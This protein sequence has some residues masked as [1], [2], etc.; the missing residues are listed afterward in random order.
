M[1]I[2]LGIFIFFLVNNLHSQE[3]SLDSLV[4]SFQKQDILFYSLLENNIQSD[5]IQKIVL[6]SEDYIPPVLF[7]LAKN[8]LDKSQSDKALYYY[9][10]ADLRTRID[11]GENELLYDR[12]K[13]ILDLYK[14]HFGKSLSQT[15][16]KY[17]E[18]TYRIFEDAA[19]EVERTSRNYSSLWLYFDGTEN[20]QK[21]LDLNEEL[22]NSKSLNSKEKILRQAKKDWEDSGFE[23]NRQ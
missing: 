17:P 19:A 9:F 13:E 8:Y 4:L 21:L 10:I 22:A 16:L 20:Q 15:F 23:L 1:R 18:K 12:R 14:F 6:K 2:L 3:N 11:L 5:E 7:A